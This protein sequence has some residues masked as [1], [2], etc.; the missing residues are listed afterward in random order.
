VTFLK[1]ML[2]EG[3]LTLDFE[4]EVIDATCVSHGGEVR[5]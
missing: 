1:E 3:E 4:N 5:K 2:D